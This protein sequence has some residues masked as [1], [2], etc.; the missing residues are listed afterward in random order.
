M[1]FR[2]GFSSAFDLSLQLYSQF[3]DRRIQ[4]LA[5]DLGER[6]TVTVIQ[7]S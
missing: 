3:I 7:M 1:N 6:F 4:Y 2:D 5:C